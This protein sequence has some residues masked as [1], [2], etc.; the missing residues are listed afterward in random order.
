MTSRWST[1]T[2]APQTQLAK[3]LTARSHVNVWVAT[4]ET[5][6]SVFWVKKCSG[7]SC[8][9]WREISGRVNANFCLYYENLGAMRTAYTQ[10]TGLGLNTSQTNAN[11]H[12]TYVSMWSKGRIVCEEHFSISL[13]HLMMA[14]LL[15]NCASFL[16]F[17]GKHFRTFV[18]KCIVD[19]RMGDASSPQKLARPL[20]KGT[21]VL[22]LRC[23]C[24]VC[25][26]FHPPVSF[27]VRSRSV[28]LRRTPQIW[29]QNGRG[30]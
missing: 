27:H 26:R 20:G 25:V 19:L 18:R 14:K 2:T 22:L 13:N 9:L 1:V 4:Q 21:T 15:L 29:Q 12:G 7:S 8:R 6:P 28:K 11:D 5:V 24:V 23:D 16:Y 3:T 30:L 17:V 10:K